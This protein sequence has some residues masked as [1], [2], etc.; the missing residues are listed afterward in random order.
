M[1]APFR[2]VIDFLP[3]QKKWIEDDSRFKIGMFTRRGGKT[4]GSCGEIV[5]DCLKAEID[6][7]KIRWTILSR[8]E[9]TAK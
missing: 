1:S 6:H 7:R 5:N 2:P 4:F 9:N 3:Y 8:S